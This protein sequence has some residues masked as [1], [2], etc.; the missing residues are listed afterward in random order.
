MYDNRLGPGA[1][2]NRTIQEV[3]EPGSVFKPLIMAAGI[4]SGEV[5]PTTTFLE[6]GPVQ[7]G[8]FTIHTALDEYHGIQ[9][10]TNVLETSSNVGMVSWLFAWEKPLCIVLLPINMV[11][12]TIP[13]SNSIKKNREKYFLKR[14]VRCSFAHCK[15]WSGTQRNTITSR[16]CMGSSCQRRCNDATTNHPGKAL[17]KRKERSIRTNSSSTSYFGRYC[18]YR[19]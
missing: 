1:F 11:L 7:V 4:E 5:T 16:S 14:L 13:M 8:D 6:D 17:S 12:E 2:V 10:M 18:Y 3:Y 15:F 19:P 9:T